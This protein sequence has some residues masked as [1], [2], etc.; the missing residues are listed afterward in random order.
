M[1]TEKK[2][3]G[4]YVA[5]I[6]PFDENGKL[7]SDRARALIERHIEVGINGF[8]VCGSSGEGY[9]QTL[10]ERRE[11]MQFV[12]DVTAKRATLIAQVGA[13]TSQDAWTLA[14][15][16]AASEY[17]VISS[18]PPFY[19]RYSSAELVEY[20]KDL[21]SR[22]AL[23]LLL[24]NAPHTTGFSL[25]LD[26]QTELLNLPTVIGSK[27]TSPDLFS[28]ERLIRGVPGTQI[29]NGPD[30]ALTAGLSMGMAG[31]IGTTYNF[32]PRHFLDIYRHVAAGDMESARTSQDI[33]NAVVRELINISPSVIPGVKL[34]LKFLGFDVGYARKP[35]QKITADTKLFEK[36]L[37]NCDGI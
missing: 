17:D 27:H 7:D 36:L 29:M 10:D 6:T 9:L 33:V 26:A 1:Y 11:Y 3:N 25:S 34:A 13:L 32:M 21:A 35:F 19:Y 14:E 31:G 24:Y 23:P 5:L 20:Y 28:A 22:S 37:T 4:I 30:E 15:Y 2:L 16:A 12:S 18:T 8:F